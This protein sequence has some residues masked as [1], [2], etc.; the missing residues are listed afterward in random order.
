MKPYDPDQVTTSFALIPLKG[1]A[2]GTFI[3]VSRITEAFTSVVGSDG[4]VARSKSNDNRR[5]IELTLLQTSDSNDVLSALHTADLEAPNGA[6]VAPFTIKDGGRFLLVAPVAWIVQSPDEEF[7][8]EATGRTWVFET[9]ND[10]KVF[11]GGS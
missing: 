10:V 1:F 2:D 9:D 7:G 3:N 11:D 8:R 5:R 6:G 4:E